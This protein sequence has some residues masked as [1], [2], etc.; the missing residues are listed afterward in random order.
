MTTSLPRSETPTPTPARTT[1]A[2]AFPRLEPV[3]GR[4]PSCSSP[5]L[6]AFYEVA[7]IP[8]NS[9]ILTQS[10]AEARRFPTGELSLAACPACGFVTNTRFDP[11]KTEYSSRYEET[12]AFSGT[13][14]RFARELAERLVEQYRLHGKTALEIGC[15]KG[16]FLVLLSELSGG[17]G[18]GIDPGYHP[19]RTESEAAARIEFVRDFY[20]ERYAHLQADFICCRHTLEHI[21]P[22]RELLS[23]LRRTIGERHD[24]LVFFEVPD[25]LRVLREGAFW[26]IYHEHCSYFTPGSLARLFRATGFEVVDLWLDYD[27]QYICLTARPADGPTPPR[28]PLEDDL[29]EVSAAVERFRATC[30][31]AIERWRTTLDAAAKAERRVVLWGSGS[32]GVSFLTTLGEPGATVEYVVDINPFK[33]GK[34]M[35]ITGQEIVSP[36]FLRDY[37]P[38]QVIVMNPIYVDEIR[39]DLARLGL[40][41]VVEAV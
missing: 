18:I 20:S 32:K 33:H 34:F 12:Q 1:A 36:D 30:G 13:F 15:G 37:R 6:R 41:P 39:R 28:L 8:V 31:G 40:S 17:R 4:C 29:T 21:A 24:A 9:C 26:D 2:T 10:P 25:V 5:G 3:A 16:E 23:T 35:P 19:E 11:Q 7:P 27:D 14:N 38:D 22:T